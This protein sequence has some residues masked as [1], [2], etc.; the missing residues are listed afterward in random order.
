MESGKLIKVEALPRESEYVQ[1]QI[2]EVL[3]RLAN[4]PGALE[5]CCAAPT[6]CRTS[7]GT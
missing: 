5:R 4:N 3:R 1:E 7:S 2:I 6:D